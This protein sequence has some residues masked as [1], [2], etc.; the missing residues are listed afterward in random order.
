MIRV[1]HVFSPLYGHTFSG[2]NKWWTRLFQEWSK[3]Q[4]QHLILLPEDDKFVE[5]RAIKSAF[6]DSNSAAPYNYSRMRRAVWAFQVLLNLWWYRK[7]FDLIHVHIQN[8]AGLLIGPFS[9]LIGRPSV[10]SIVRMESDDPSTLLKESFGHVKLWCFKRYDRILC[11]SEALRQDCLMNNLKEEQV[12]MLISAVDTSVFAPATSP[13]TK[14]I[15]RLR[16]ELPL[17]AD[18]ILSVGSVIYRKGADLL[19]DAFISL[20]EV[21]QNLYVVF[22]GPASQDTSIGINENFVRG[23]RNRVE[24]LGLTKRV[25]FVGRV[26]NDQLLANYYKAVDIFA[27]PTRQEGLGY[28]ILEA[29]SSELPVITSYLPGI[30]DMLVKEGITGFIIPTEDSQALANRIAI[31]AE[32]KKLRNEIGKNSREWV[33]RHL[34][35]DRWQT[36]IVKIY[37]SLMPETPLIGT[38]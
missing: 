21:Y 32:N 15:T 10:R 4:L 13:D 23:L 22:V 7:S 25:L 19:L 9:H 5:A 1:L 14:N 3:E 31:L 30:T 18:I 8:W 34:T 27:F 35:Y 2:E 20:A 12:K 29:M 6:G 38:V 11:L 37:E 24:N 26:D 36:E 33:A 17:S 28:V 16:L